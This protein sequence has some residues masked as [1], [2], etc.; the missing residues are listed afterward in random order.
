[1]ARNRRARVLFWNGAALRD[2][3]KLVETVMIEGGGLL[4]I[5]FQ[6]DFTCTFGIRERN[7]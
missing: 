3:N 7:C 5:P 1:M 6:Q 2:A 4:P